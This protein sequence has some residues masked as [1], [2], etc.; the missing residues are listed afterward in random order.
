MWR[1]IQEKVGWLCSSPIFV[2]T[3]CV[4]IEFAALKKT[5]E[6]AF[7]KAEMSFLHQR[8]YHT[9]YRVNLFCILSLLMRVLANCGRERKID[10]LTPLSTSDHKIGGKG[11]YILH[12]MEP[13]HNGNYLLLVPRWDF[14]RWAELW[15]SW[16]VSL[17]PFPLPLPSFFRLFSP[18]FYVVRLTPNNFMASVLFPIR[19]Q[20]KLPRAFGTWKPARSTQRKTHRLL[21]VMFSHYFV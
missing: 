4:H 21:F 16:P 2:F 6:I 15:F 17:P 12:I 9:K 5:Y 3:Q 14:K 13:L 11:F 1:N 8:V 18:F 20:L 10:Y 7:V 19:S